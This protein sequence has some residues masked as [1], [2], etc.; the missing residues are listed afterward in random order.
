[1]D[2]LDWLLLLGAGLLGGVINSVSSGGSFITYPA[3]LL[4]GLSPLLLLIG[5]LIRLTSSGPALFQQKRYGF[6]NEEFTVYKFRTMRT[7][8]AQ[9][10]AAPGSKVDQA[11]RDD[12]RITGTDQLVVEALELRARLRRVRRRS[13]QRELDQQPQRLERFAEHVRPLPRRHLRQH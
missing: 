8:A 3:L 7:E 6:N 12:P 5:L 1:M 11:T 9:T 4:V 2:V 10:S 13:K